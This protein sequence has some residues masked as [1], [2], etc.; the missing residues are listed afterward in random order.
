MEMSDKRKGDVEIRRGKVRN[1]DKKW[2]E[3]ELR[4]KR[5]GRREKDRDRKKGQ[6][7]RQRWENR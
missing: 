7:G 2:R 4:E 1:T 3:K 6:G 5:D